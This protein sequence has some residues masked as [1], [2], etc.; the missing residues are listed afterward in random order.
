MVVNEALASGLPCIVSKNCGC[1]VDL[2]SHNKSGFIFDP[3]KKNELSLLMKVVENQ[4]NEERKEMIRHARNNLKKFDLDSFVISLKKA[5]DQAI[6]EPKYSLSSRFLL[7]I[8]S[9]I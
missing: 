5:I 9:I 6:K 4:S 7:K 2:I 3:L 8:I 1:A